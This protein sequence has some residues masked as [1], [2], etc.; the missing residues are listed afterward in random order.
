M[1]HLFFWKKKEPKKRRPEGET[2]CG[3]LPLSC[4]VIMSTAS[5]WS[6]RYDF[7]LILHFCTLW[8][9]SLSSL[10]NPEP[11]T[12]TRACSNHTQTPSEKDSK[13]WQD[14]V[15]G[16]IRSGYLSISTSTNRWT[17]PPLEFQ[18][19]FGPLVRTCVDRSKWVMQLYEEESKSSKY[20]ICQSRK[21]RFESNNNVFFWFV[22]FFFSGSIPFRL[23][24][25]RSGEQIVWAEEVYD[26]RLQQ[27]Q[28]GFTQK[29]IASQ[30]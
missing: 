7:P 1:K 2:P 6:L 22:I 17:K 14:L 9:S 29:K 13:S 16:Q 28:G 11:E 18:C 4:L 5:W 8:L 21:I 19:L 10:S 20:I 25:S 15:L 12:N 3:A 27:I 23:I 30:I 26:R 24:C